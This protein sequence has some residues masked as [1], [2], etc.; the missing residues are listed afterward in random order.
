[1][2]NNDFERIIQFTENN[3]KE[4][5]WKDLFHQNEAINWESSNY[6]SIKNSDTFPACDFYY[7]NNSYTIELEVPGID[8]SNIHVRLEE[9]SFIIEGKYHSFKKNCSYLL[10]ERQHKH[11]QKCISL[12][13]LMNE[14]NIKASFNNGI[15]LIKLTPSA[16]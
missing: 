12:P 15:L 2:G 8:P 4:N 9:N 14:N 5:Y 7:A 13:V 16:K 3:H 11:F 10:K 6:S 1:M